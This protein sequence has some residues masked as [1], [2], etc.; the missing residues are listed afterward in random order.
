M[1]AVFISVKRL[2]S[3]SCKGVAIRAAKESPP[4]PETEA[5]AL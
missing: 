1:S 3:R 2:I 5:S 4:A